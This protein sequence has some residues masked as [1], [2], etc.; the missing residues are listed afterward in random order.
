MVPEGACSRPLPSCYGVRLELKRQEFNL[1]FGIVKSAR[2]KDHI[3]MQ[4]KSKMA[5]M[6]RPMLHS[7]CAARLAK[8]SN[9]GQSRIVTG[10]F[11]GTVDLWQRKYNL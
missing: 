11:G 7:S 10:Q 8:H 3:R 4:F 2:N 1:S 5:R 6:T 9:L